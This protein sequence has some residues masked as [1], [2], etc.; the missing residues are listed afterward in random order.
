[1]KKNPKEIALQRKEQGFSL[2]VNGANCGSAGQAFTKP[3]KSP[4]RPISRKTKT[5]GGKMMAI[6]MICGHFYELF[7]VINPFVPVA[8]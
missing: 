7:I 1:M 5:A 4:G 8:P 6:S 3:L 2:Y